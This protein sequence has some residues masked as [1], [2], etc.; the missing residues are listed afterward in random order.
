MRSEPN[1]LNKKK[2]ENLQKTVSVK[3][4]SNK[5]AANT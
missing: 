3:L 5:W 1:D 2:R 4:Q